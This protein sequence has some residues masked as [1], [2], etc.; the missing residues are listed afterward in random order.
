MGARRLGRVHFAAATLVK[1]Q[2]ESDGSIAPPLV[3][4][5][6]HEPSELIMNQRARLVPGGQEEQTAKAAKDRLEA[7]AENRSVSPLQAEH[8]GIYKGVA[9]K[10]LRGRSGDVSPTAPRSRPAQ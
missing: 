1:R 4:H 5:L 2:L 6:S 9:L 10:L 3:L 8:V 7:C